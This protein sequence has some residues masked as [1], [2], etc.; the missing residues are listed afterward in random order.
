MSFDLTWGD[1]PNVNHADHRAVGLAALDACRDAAN[2]WSF[3]DAG[4]P[5]DGAHEVYVFA[6]AGATHYVDVTEHIDRGVASLLEHRV[7]MDGLGTEFDPDD[8]LRGSAR[9]SGEGVGVPLAV[10]FRQY[11]T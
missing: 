3:P 4:E 10:T 6:A 1:G 11:H 8:F 9:S 2:R 5:W 7:Y